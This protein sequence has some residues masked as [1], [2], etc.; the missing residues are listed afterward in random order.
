MRAPA[1]GLTPALSRVAPLQRRPP[2][3]YPLRYPLRQA[4]ELLTT[5]AA[6]HDTVTRRRD[7][8]VRAAA[9]AG[10][11]KSEIH[12]LTGIARTTIDRI[13]GS[14]HVPAEEGAAK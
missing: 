7:D 11:S 6:D 5:W 2:R 4:R 3:V 13:T 1:P 14:G 9:G 8:V 12:R 10:V